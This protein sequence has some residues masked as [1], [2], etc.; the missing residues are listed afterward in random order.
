MLPRW[1]VV[2][3]LPATAGNIR[4]VG[5]IPEL[6]RSPREGNAP[7]PVFLPRESHG[8]RSLVDYGPKGLEKSD[9]TEATYT[10]ACVHGQGGDL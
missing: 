10:H 3:N 7:T 6:G 5:L 9:T 4:D 1:C 8:Q 2:K